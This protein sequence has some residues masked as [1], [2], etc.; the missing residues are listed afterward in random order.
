MLIDKVV[1]ST[2]N[3]GLF[4]PPTLSF[5]SSKVNP[6]RVV[7]ALRV[8]TFARV[9]RVANLHI[10]SVRALHSHVR[11]EPVGGHNYSPSIEVDT[12]DL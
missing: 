12:G 3:F 9:F 10:I 11:P 1:P 5:R 6:E 4:F 8:I 2:R 7:M